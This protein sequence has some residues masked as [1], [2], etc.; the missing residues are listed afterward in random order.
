M[1]EDLAA[2]WLTGETVD[3]TIFCTL[4]NIERRQLESVGI[5]RRPRDVTQSLT[6]YLQNR[7]DAA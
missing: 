4:A 1:S 5:K 6:H 7:G 2:R 3:P